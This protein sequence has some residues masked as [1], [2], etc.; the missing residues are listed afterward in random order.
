MT[1]PSRQGP[2]GPRKARSACRPEIKELHIPETAIL[3]L[4]NPYD[5]IKVDYTNTKIKVDYTD[6]KVDKLCLI[7]DI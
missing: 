1:R 6:T 4:Y 2:S 7:I 5:A 3:E